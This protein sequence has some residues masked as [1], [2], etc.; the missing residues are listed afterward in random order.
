MSEDRNAAKRAGVAVDFLVWMLVLLGVPLIVVPALNQ[1]R[2]LAVGLGIGVVVA[3]GAAGQV[4]RGL[5]ERASSS[6]KSK[7]LKALGC[8]LGAAAYVAT[9]LVGLVNGAPRLLAAWLEHT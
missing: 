8:H 3:L 6:E 5:G 9:A 1:H 2:E 4:L 7:K